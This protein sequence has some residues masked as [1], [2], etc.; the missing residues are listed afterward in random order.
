MDGWS[1]VWNGLW[2]GAAVLPPLDAAQ[3][4]LRLGWG[5]VLAA[6]LLSALGLLWR[7]RA[8]AAWGAGLARAVTAAVLL[9]CV[10]PGEGSASFWLG[11]AFQAPSLG[12]AAVAVLVLL[13]QGVLGPV[14]AAGAGVVLVQARG[15]AWVGVVLGWVLLLDSFAVW[16][17]YLYPSGFSAGSVVVLLALALLPWAWQGGSWRRQRAALGWVA[18][19]G[20]FVL[21]RWPSGNAWDALLDPWLCLLCHGVLV[22]DACSR[23]KKHSFQRNIHKG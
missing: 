23:Y 20:L 18:L 8:G 6:L 21:T 10:L 19:L 4:W 5:L 14:G 11:L 22:G 2:A 9:W 16:P 12:T 15:W 1:A 13:R 3:V 17:V 7:R